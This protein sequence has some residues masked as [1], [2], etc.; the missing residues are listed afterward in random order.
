MKTARRAY[1]PCRA[2][3]RK[4]TPLLLAVL[5]LIAL[6]LVVLLILLALVLLA[7]LVLVVAVLHTDTPFRLS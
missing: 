5:L 2:V 3:F 4:R 6:V 1:G 7:I